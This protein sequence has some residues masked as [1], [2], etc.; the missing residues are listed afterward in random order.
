MKWRGNVL[1]IPLRGRVDRLLTAGVN[2]NRL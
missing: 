1:T 2:E